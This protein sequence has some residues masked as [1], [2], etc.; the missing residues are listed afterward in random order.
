MQFVYICLVFSSG[1]GECL[2]N[3]PG[4]KSARMS[5]EAL[6]GEKWNGTEQCRLQYGPRSTQCKYGVITGFDAK[7][8]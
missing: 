7:I 5:T 1:F 6:P 4:K 8:S 2:N 3:R